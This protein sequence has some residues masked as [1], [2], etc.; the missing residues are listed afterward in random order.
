[1]SEACTW[2]PCLGTQCLESAWHADAF[3][4]GKTGT[5]WSTSW[6]GGTAEVLLLGFCTAW[7]SDFFLCSCVW[8]VG[9]WGEPV[10]KNCACFFCVHV[11]ASVEG[12]NVGRIKEKI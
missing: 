2:V 1:M 7:I 6:V 4:F 10:C 9:L 3:V 11:Q 5:P 12:Y 8:E